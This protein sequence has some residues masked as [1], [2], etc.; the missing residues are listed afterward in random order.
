MALLF[1]LFALSFDF[2]SGWP[3]GAPCLRTVYE[4]M[5]PLEAVE[6]QGGL[7][8]SDPP[9]TIELDAQCY[10]P[11]QPIS[12]CLH[13]NGSTEFKGFA[14]Q[15]LVFDAFRVGT[16]RTGQFL[17]MDDNGSWQFQCFRIRD[18]VTHSHDDKKG[19]MTMWWRGDFNGE[20]VQ[21][22]AT[23]VQNLKRFWVKSVVS[24]PIPPCSTRASF[25]PWNKGTPTVPPPTDNFKK[26]TF[27]LFNPGSAAQLISE[28]SAV[29]AEGRSRLLPRP[30]SPPS[31]PDPVFFRTPEPATTIA[32]T[33]SFFRPNQQFQRFG[34]NSACRDK[35]S[36]RHCLQ[37]I[38]F[39]PTNPWMGQFCKATCRIISSFLLD[40]QMHPSQH[41]QLQTFGNS[42]S[43]NSAH[44]SPMKRVP[45]PALSPLASPM[46]SRRLFVPPASAHPPASSSADHSMLNALQ[47]GYTLAGPA[48]PARL[49][50]DP[51][52]GQQYFVPT[53]PQPMPYFAAPTPLYYPNQFY[54]TPASTATAQSQSG[55]MFANQPPT[56]LWSPQP[57]S[58]ATP[59]SLLR[60]RAQS[61]SAVSSALGGRHHHQTQHSSSAYHVEVPLSSVGSMCEEAEF[62]QYQ[63]QQEAFQRQQQIRL[64]SESRGSLRSAVGNNRLEMNSNRMDLNGN[65]RSSPPQTASGHTQSVPPRQLLQLQPDHHSTGGSS[66]EST[67][68][69]ASGRD[70][71]RTGDISDGRSPPQSP[72]MRKERTHFLSGQDEDGNH[73]R[74]DSP[75]SPSLPKP[76]APRMKAI[77]MDIDL[78]RP[79]SPPEQRQVSVRTTVVRTAPPTAFTISF[80]DVSSK[81]MDIPNSTDRPVET[82]HDVREP[83]LQE[84]ARQAPTGRRLMATRRNV[85]PRPVPERGERIGTDSGDLRGKDSEDGDGHGDELG[86]DAEDMASETGT[87]VVES[88]KMSQSQP[89]VTSTVSP[90]GEQ[91]GNSVHPSTCSPSSSASSSSRTPSPSLMEGKGA[92]RSLMSDLRR[93]REQKSAATPPKPRAFPPAV[94][95]PQR[96]LMGQNRPCR[97]QMPSSNSTKKTGNSPFRP[98][99]VGGGGSRCRSEPRSDGGRFSMRGTQPMKGQP[100]AMPAKD[101]AVHQQSPEMVAWLRRKEYDPRKAAAAASTDQSQKETHQRQQEAFMASRSFSTSATTKSPFARWR[102]NRKTLATGDQRSNRSHDDLS[103]L[104][105]SLDEESL[106]GV[107]VDSCSSSLQRTVDELTQK[108]HKSIAL[109][110]LCNQ[111]GLSSSVEQLLERV[112]E[113]ESPEEV[114]DQFGAVG[115]DGKS[116]SENISDRLERLSSAFDAIQKY[117]EEQTSVSSSRASLAALGKMATT[118]ESVQKTNAEN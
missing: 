4:S 10:Y 2:S 48:Q 30:S 109:L 91:S 93:L 29:P 85:P 76:P 112:V 84:A 13:G 38:Q 58:S 42:A 47:L 16:R 61:P 27:E 8:L 20:T 32:T 68:G 1:L 80:N 113:G 46:E 111:S 71:L 21:F 40:D 60:Q 43:A 56:T 54:P 19:R 44:S 88:K 59:P 92:K 116:N 108:C 49:L 35:T 70:R 83:S 50:V 37:W 25:G 31:Q 63:H 103:R 86:D 89:P 33:P 82:G 74:S 102:Q 62:E 115:S 90:R 22:V 3:D 53:A 7:Q 14:M 79:V 26:E 39:C 100:N 23:V 87:Y 99:S 114:E 24:M 75:K 51:H 110:K 12:V 96:T 64:S 73:R 95:A 66:S 52:T 69:F 97:Q 77:R 106:P 101:A 9:F 41:Q 15:S 28:I 104:G 117:L 98:N 81:A 94:P 105:E 6:H 36:S 67:S 55:F 57:L 118:T 5:N 45:P 18:S 72:F 78:N 17:R 34:Q 11:G 107:A 65:D